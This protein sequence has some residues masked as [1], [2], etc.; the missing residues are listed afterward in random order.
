MCEPPV[1]SPV[2]DREETLRGCGGLSLYSCVWDPREPPR[3]CVG[4][5]HGLGEHCGRYG[6]LVTHLTACGYAVH[7]FDQRGHGRSPGRRGHVAAWREYIEDVA[8]F[9]NRMVE[10]PFTSSKEPG[11]DGDPESKSAAASAS[12]SGGGWPVFLYGH[13]MGALEVLDYALNKPGTVAGVIANAP[14]FE[15]VAIKSPLRLMLARV[16]SRAWPTFALRTRITVEM[17]SRDAAV[18]EAC[19]ADPL[20]HDEVTARWGAEVMRAIVS[21]R[22]RAGELRTPVLLLHGGADRLAS[23][24]GSSRF[25]EQLTL[26]DRDLHIYEGAFHESHNDLCWREAVEDVARWIAGRVTGKGS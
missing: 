20:M 7:G 3:A 26:A 21:V 19:A 23:A 4:L 17:M 6:R 13:S 1:M 24:A 18:C 2:P 22:R 9:V 14:P 11:D 10:A 8:R 25:F 12:A 5:V 15:P 16:L